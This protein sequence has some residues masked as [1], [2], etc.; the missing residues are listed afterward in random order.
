M[1]ARTSLMR[2]TA[3]NPPS[4]RTMLSGV[5]ALTVVAFG[6]LGT[7]A[8]QALTTAQARNLIDRLVAEINRVINSGKSEQA[9]YRDFEKIFAKYSDVPAIARYALGV[10][11]RRATPAQM[12]A[13][14]KAFQVY[15]SHKYGKRFREFIGGK[16]VVQSARKLKKFYEVKTTALLRGQSP[17]EV[18]F[19][20]SDRSGKDL[21]FNI[22][23]EGINMLLSERDEIGAML[24][25]R[26]GN[27][28]KL[29]ADL[30]NAA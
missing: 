15:I 28:N 12:R 13:F 23:I 29:I 19:H 20:V 17:F 6:G 7:S 22:F 27:I 8:A 18:D 1:K 30:K 24:D 5:A 14:T 9:M 10:D 4:R 25:K 2:F 26:G 21:F 3:S 16:L 11:A